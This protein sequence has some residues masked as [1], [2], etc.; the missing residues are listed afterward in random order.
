MVVIA[1]VQGRTVA[2]GLPEPRAQSAVV[3]ALV[4]DSPAHEAAVLVVQAESR[5]E[6]VVRERTAGSADLRRR[7]PVGRRG[8]VGQALKQE[9]AEAAREGAAPAVR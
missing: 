7:E 2:L 6:A 5:P 4:V 1:G 8:P 3:A 9:L